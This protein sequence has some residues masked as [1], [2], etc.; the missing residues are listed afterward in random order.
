MKRRFAFF[1]LLAGIALIATA[2]PQQQQPGPGGDAQE[3]V[4]LVFVGPTTGPVANLGIGPRN[5]AELAIQQANEAG[6]LDVEIEF[7]SFDTQGDPDQATALKDDFIEDD[8]VIG[9]IGPT[10][11]GETEAVIPDLQAN[12]LA[13]I[14]P[15]ATRTTL[16]TEPE[17]DQTIFHRVVP[18]D[19]VQGAGITEYVTEVLDLSSLYY[20]HDNQ[21]YGQALAEGTQG[22]LEA[23]DVTTAGTD[24]IDP[25]QSVY[26]AQVTAVNRAAPPAVY[27][28]GYYDAGGKLLKQLR[29]EGYE[30]L[31]IVGDG[32]LDVGLVE[33]AG[34]EAAEGAIVTCA[35]RLAGG[36]TEGDLGEFATAYEEEFDIPAGVYATEGFDSA[37]VFIEGIRQGNI[38]RESMLA[39]LEEEF[40]TFEGL[41]KEIGFEENGNV[42]TGE[43]LVYEVTEGR[44]TLLGP[45]SE[46]T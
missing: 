17:A 4:K 23:E 46:L 35:C 1:A 27:F 33:N 8:S 5:G 22:L 6:D 43:V 15:S 2:C 13:M 40:E 45:A 39:F 34:A 20:I 16:P 41:S 38:D 29:D 31:F 18:D 25:A 28:G 26:S 37:N 21:A 44:L 10:F 36:E 12:G 11:S 19:D 9:V 7:E 32:G 42:T 14:S 30:G 3:T 24:T